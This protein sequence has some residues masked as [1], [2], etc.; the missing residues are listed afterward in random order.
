MIKYDEKYSFMEYTYIVFVF[1]GKKTTTS[2]YWYKKE[3][4]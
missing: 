3:E 2:E 1:I 4:I